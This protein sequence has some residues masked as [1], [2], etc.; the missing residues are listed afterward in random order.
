MN[1][2]TSVQEYVANQPRFTW[3]RNILR[4][5][6]RSVGFGL[7]WKV[8]VCNPQNVPNEGPVIIMMNHTSLI[9]PILCMGAITN[10]FV[11]PMTKVENLRN[12]IIRPF[13]NWWGSYSVNR[14]EV[15]RK[16]LVNSIEL[17]KSGQLILIAPE[18]T[19]QKTGLTEAKD[20]LAYIAT[21]ADAVIVPTGISGA[22][23]WDENLKRLRRTHITINFGR[24]FRFRTGGRTRIPREE[25]TA[26]SHEAMYQLALAITDPGL[27]G[28]YSDVSQAT[29][30]YLDY[31]QP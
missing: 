19:R 6:I 25:L 21:K 31:L 2:S 12:P 30:N 16:A 4:A 24:P 11:I 27:R 7:I 23:G 29:S 9:D 13:I 14:G 15:D 26:M 18:G 10:R 3:R 5:L 22:I 17:V 28:V 20:G 1:L 8:Q